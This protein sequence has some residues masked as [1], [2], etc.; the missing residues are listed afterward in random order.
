MSV[1]AELAAK[2]AKLRT[3]YIAVTGRP[4]EHFY[5]PI[6]FRDEDTPLCQAHVINEGF[7]D[8]AR[9]WTIQRA[10]LDAFYGT[11]LEADFLAIQ[12]RGKHELSHILVDNRLR[13][14]LRPKLLLDGKPLEYYAAHG[15]IPSTFTELQVDRGP[16]TQPARLALKLDPSEALRRL[17]GKLEIEVKMDVRVSALGALLKAAH[18]TLFELQGYRYALSAGGHFLGFDV[19]GRFY[20]AHVG[21]GKLGSKRLKERIR[22]SAAEHFG[23]FVNLVRPVT[24]WP[25]EITGTISDRFVYMCL[26]SPLPWGIITFIRTAD[27]MHAVLVPVMEDAEAG[28]RFVRFLQEPTS[29]IEVKLARFC[30]DHWEISPTATRFQWPEATL[31]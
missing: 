12:E 1:N 9:R 16:D 23:E 11:Y 24:A 20:L 8:S 26:G 17:S 22:S 10:D 29:S 6:L 21:A 5:C 19:L 28:A 15:A 13:R 27:V 25:K 4:F 3:D 30:W 18:L 2:L 14:Q 7:R 31:A